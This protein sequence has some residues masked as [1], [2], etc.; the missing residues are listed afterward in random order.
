MFN[1]LIWNPDEIRI[2]PHT[3]VALCGT[4]NSGKTTFAERAFDKELI[5][6]SD[7]AM[8]N[9]ANNL[10]RITEE[11]LQITTESESWKEISTHLGRIAYLKTQESL[12]NMVF[13]SSREH[14]ITVFDSVHYDLQSRLVAFEKYSDFFENIFLIVI[15]PSLEKIKSRKVKTISK[16]LK[17]MGFRFSDEHEITS[18]HYYLRNQIVSGQI[19]LGTTKTFVIENTDN[20]KITLL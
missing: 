6:N 15:N 19:A 4:A 8:E 14:P 20:L 7:T 2:P 16:S 9:F 5:I 17:A 11:D 10:A 1:D 3:L 12:L 18:Q 13:Q